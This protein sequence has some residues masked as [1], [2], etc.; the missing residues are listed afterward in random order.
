M[1]NKVLALAL[2]AEQLTHTLA[3]A[4]G[5]ANRW[6]VLVDDAMFS[7]DWF[8]FSQPT[9]PTTSVVRYMDY[10]DAHDVAHDQFYV[11]LGQQCLRSTQKFLNFAARHGFPSYKGV[12]LVKVI[13]AHLSSLHV[14]PFL[15]HL[16]IFE[17]AIKRE[18]P[19]EVWVYRK[20]HW[21]YVIREPRYVPQ[22]ARLDHSSIESEALVRVAQAHGIAVRFCQPP[23]AD[24][25]RYLFT[26]RARPF[27]VNAYRQVQLVKAKVL[28]DKKKSGFHRSNR[29]KPRVL[30]L[31]RSPVHQACLIP[32]LQELEQAGW[33]LCILN[34]CS[35]IVRQAMKLPATIPQIGLA[36]WQ[37]AYLYR[38][39]EL[40]SR[41]QRWMEEHRDHVPEI[42]YCGV[43]LG[44]ILHSI[45]AQ[46][47]D[48]LVEAASLIDAFENILDVYAPSII[49]TA[50]DQDLPGRCLIEM[51]RQHRIPSM[52]VQHGLIPCP[53]L[54]S[55]PVHADKMVVMGQMPADLLT[56]FGTPAETVV[57]TGIPGFDHGKLNATHGLTITNNAT[58][59]LITQNLPS[60]F[61]IALPM[62]LHLASQLPAEIFVIKVS[63]QEDKSKYTSALPNIRVV[64][65]TLSEVLA[66]SKLVIGYNSTALIEAMQL[67]LPVLI[68]D[69]IREYQNSFLRITGNQLPLDSAW[70]PVV[71]RLLED[72]EQRQALIE[73]Q[74]KFLAYM[75]RHEPG[76]AKRIATLINEMVRDDAH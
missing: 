33:E 1:C 71:R 60:L 49:L 37:A 47:V 24:R 5:K 22:V 35:L 19:D 68:F 20:P 46:L 73:R 3:G 31:I 7:T 21:D 29:G 38:H 54:Y 58:I 64:T 13:H 25:G 76:A 67:N 27:A 16:F 55:M 75:L 57:I 14:W 51:G 12:S 72:A 34:D 17:Q 10:L 63:P 6:V 41:C 4:K 15:Q 23:F 70:L 8:Q 59:T 74:N 18:Q 48:K 62:F 50:Y 9:E 66:T 43:G 69:Q 42:V 32:V 52:N 40:G 11:D 56:A 53:P 65:G 28:A 44:D 30:A 45:L 61:R 39:R 2:S 26:K 36:A